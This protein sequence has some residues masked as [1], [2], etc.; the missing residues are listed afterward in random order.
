MFI[1]SI[2]DRLSRPVD[3]VSGKMS[4]KS[5]ARL[6]NIHGYPMVDFS[7]YSIAGSLSVSIACSQSYPYDLISPDP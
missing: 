2:R 4:V 1:V 7:V 6:T 3:S 5:A